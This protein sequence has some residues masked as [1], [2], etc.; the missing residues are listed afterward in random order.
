V[1]RADRGEPDGVR[2]EVV[3]PDVVRDALAVAFD[4]PITTDG[5]RR[6]GPPRLPRQML[7]DQAYDGHAS[8]HDGEVADKLGLTGAPIEGPTHFSQFDPL[9]WDLWGQQWFE[10]GCISAHFQTMVVEGESVSASATRSADR[11][12]IARIDAV[13]G[14]GTPVLTGTMSV[15][16][17]AP[18]E[19][20]DRLVKMQA[21]DPGDLYI[22]DQVVVG[23]R[24]RHDDPVSID[25]D[26]DNG[27][28]Y[29]FSLRQKLAAITEPSSWYDSHDNPWGRP[30]VPFEMFS[31]LTNKV[32]NRLHVRGP[33]VGLFIDLEVRA[34]GT[35]L[36]VGEEYVLEREVVC[37]GQSRQ[38]ESHWVETVVRSAVSGAPVAS[39]LLHS[40][41]FKASYAGYPT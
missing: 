29:P 14:D 39:V 17:L 37:V 8:V 13:K 27:A 6:E 18:T 30:I 1:R 15:D 16:P 12:G 5:D 10:T 7:H 2:F 33:A 34:L 22:V 32:G 20:R 4:T 41:V 3:S 21:R 31:V 26:T 35:P 9:G 24:S 11:P 28:L 19:L 36:F 40:G 23:S 38:V 25:A